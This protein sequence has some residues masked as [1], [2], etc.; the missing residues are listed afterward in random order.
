MKKR[1]A[2]VA[3]SR[4]LPSYAKPPVIEVVASVQFDP[5][6]NLTVA[7]LGLLW[8]RFRD[9]FP[10]VEQKPPIAP[11]VERL[12]TRVPLGGQ[13]QFQIGDDA[14][15]PRLWFVNPDGDELIQVQADRFIRNWRAVSHVDRPYPRYEHCIRPRFLE[16]YQIFQRFMSEELG[17]AIQ[18]AQCELTY[19][20]H[21]TPNEHWN[22]HRDLA[23]V[24]KGWNAEYS[25]SVD[26]PVESIH[27]RVVHLLHD[28]AGEFLGRLHVTLQSAFKNIKQ[29]TEV[30]QPIFVLTL[31]ARGRPTKE[32]EEGLLGFLDKGHSMIVTAFDSMTTSQMHQVWEKRYD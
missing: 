1:S 13:I 7:H 32:G 8:Q 4:R 22:A 26:L 29:P 27:Q 31:I 5:L 14:G 21:I 25:K 20:N 15:V 23:A 24:F 9:R 6:P 11:V 28:D 2:S 10:K 17:V 19:I 18:P 30:E 3:S 16:D 12:G